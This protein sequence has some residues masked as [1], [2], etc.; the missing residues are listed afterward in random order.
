MKSMSHILVAAA[1]ALAMT[2]C[3]GGSKK[4]TPV[5]PPI[6]QPAYSATVLTTGTGLTAQ[7]GD[8]V[9][10]QY[11]AYLYDSTKPNS[12]GTLFDSTYARSAPVTFTLGAGQAIPQWDQGQAI[13]AWDEGVSGML[14]GGKVRLTVPASLGF[15]I[16]AQTGPVLP[17]ATVGVAIP[18]NTPLVFEVELINVQKAVVP[19][20]VP[21]PTTLYWTD[22]IVGTG[23]AIVAGSKVTVHYTVW[24]FDG[25]KS[26]T[27]GQEIDTDLNTGVSTGYV[28]TQGDPGLIAGWNQGVLGMMP[29]GKRTI[30]IP[31]SLA[32]GSGTGPSGT[33]PP[34]SALVYDIEV[35]SVQ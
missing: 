4:T 11:T 14:V 23:T 13:P 27:R 35:I 3:G 28:F 12:E 30:Y 6:V 1:C 18:A 17:G 21:V 10:I 26:D 34:N 16:V 8:L 5:T 15:G 20:T 22:D 2:A 32:Y 31:A 7:N 24:L 9:T 33:I 19:V 29:G 25:T